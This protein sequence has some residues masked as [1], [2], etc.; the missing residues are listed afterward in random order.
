MDK[1]KIAV[2]AEELQRNEDRVKMIGMA[3]TPSDPAERAKARIEYEIAIAELIQAQ[4]ELTKAQN[5]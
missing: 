5:E 3:N 4:R 1:Y 2:L